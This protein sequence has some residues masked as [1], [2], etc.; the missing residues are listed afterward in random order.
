MHAEF[1]GKKGVE[2]VLS[3]YIGGHVK[4]PTYEQVSMGDTGHVEAIEVKFDPAQVTYS[5]LLDIFWSN[6][7]PT[8]ADGQ[9]CDKGS[10][11]HAGIFYLDEAQKIAAEKSSIAIENKLGQKI[12]TFIKKADIFYPAEEYH[13]SYHKK[14]PIRYQLYKVGCGRQDRLEQLEEMHDKK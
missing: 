14:S 3:G 9:F 13:Q 6:V 8:D 12:V 11:Y 2:R 5:D 10:Q 7:D 4:D 1:E